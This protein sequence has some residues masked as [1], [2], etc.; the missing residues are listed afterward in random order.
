M[1]RM[2]SS[3]CKCG[4]GLP[5]LHG[6]YHHKQPNTMS[7]LGVDCHRV[8]MFFGYNGQLIARLNHK[9]FNFWRSWRFRAWSI[10]RN[11]G[12]RCWKWSKNPWAIRSSPSNIVDWS[13][14][15]EHSDFWHKPNTYFTLINWR[16]L[17]TT[18][19]ETLEPTG[20]NEEI[21]SMPFKS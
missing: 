7:F 9:K 5:Q 20:K 2:M 15:L 6:T 16:I 3:I 8:K 10:L 11:P 14:V 1:E 13:E 12:C 18:W 19:Q 4:N 17:G 21:S